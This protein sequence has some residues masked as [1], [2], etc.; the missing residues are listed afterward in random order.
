MAY[1]GMNLIKMA[2]NREQWPA[3]LNT[4]MDLWVQ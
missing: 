3:L 2:E 4:V 1:K